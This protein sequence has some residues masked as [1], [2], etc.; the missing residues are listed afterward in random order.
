MESRGRLRRTV[1]VARPGPRS[2]WPKGQDPDGWPSPSSYDPD[3][4]TGVPSR[5]GVRE[6]GTGSGSGSQHRRA[7]RPRPAPSGTCGPAIEDGCSRGPRAASNRPSR[8]SS[9][10]RPSRP[11]TC[12]RIP[13]SPAARTAP[14]SAPDPGR[15][16]PPSRHTGWRARSAHRRPRGCGSAA[17]AHRSSPGGPSSCPR[18]PSRVRGRVPSRGHRGT[19]AS[20][21]GPVCIAGSSSRPGPSTAGHRTGCCA[22]SASSM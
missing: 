4:G 9:S 8:R 14:S 18:G 3:R 2:A 11:G 12:G 1:P 22:P 10:Q 21:D 7:C 15:S 19:P 17:R 6:R 13:R 20:R 5:D 16:R